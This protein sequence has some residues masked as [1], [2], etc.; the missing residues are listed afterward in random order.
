MKSLVRFL[1]IGLFVSALCAGFAC[2][3]A[4]KDQAAGEKGAAPAEITQE[5]LTASVPALGELHEVVYPLWHS[6]YAEKD[7]SLIKE[8]LPR[9]DTLVANLDAAELPG[10]LRDKQEAWG[11]G[12]ANLKAA[13]QKLHDAANT[14]N[15]EEMLAQTEA[16]HAAY[17]QLV[18]TVRPVVPE[19]EAFHQDLYRLY[20]YDAPAYDLAQIRAG[21]AAMLEKMPAL[22]AAQLPKRL[23]E[24]Q[25]DFVAAV[26]EL[27]TAVNEL[28]ETVKVDE[29]AKVQAAVEKVHAAYQQA[30][31][32]FE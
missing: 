4:G 25:A 32:L 3:K 18:R 10:I 5:E 9:A 14:E 20:H 17:E 26:Q 22:K 19:L 12:K 16:F 23:A 15:T 1:V 28:A 7:F 6:A 29:K 24:R 31:K 30:E 11:E 21:A 27:E 8:L 2:Q 13:L